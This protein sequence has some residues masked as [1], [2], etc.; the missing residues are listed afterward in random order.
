MSSIEIQSY[1]GIYDKYDDIKAL[2]RQL[3]NLCGKI[4]VYSSNLKLDFINF[5][6]ELHVEVR[7]NDLSTNIKP[8]NYKITKDGIFYHVSVERIV[9]EKEWERITPAKER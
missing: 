5:P 1:Y 7:D 8:G 6:D 2:M 9:I 3:Y 4:S